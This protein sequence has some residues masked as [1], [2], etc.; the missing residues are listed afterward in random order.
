MASINYRP[1]GKSG[2]KVS[3][4]A[5]GGWTTF[6]ASVREEKKVDHILSKA[7]EAGINFFDMADVYAKGE[8]EKSMGKILKKFP[9]QH[10]VL[11]SKVFFPITQDPNDQGLSRKHIMESIHKSLKNIGS[12]YLDLYFCHRYD[13]QTPLEETVRAMDDLIHQGKILYWGTSEWSAQQLEAVQKLCAQKNYYTPIVEQAQYSLVC[14]KKFEEEILPVLED[15]QLGSVTWSPLGSGILTG[16]YDQGIPPDSR[17]GQITWLQE[18]FYQEK[19]LESVKQFKKIAEALGVSRS[20]LA[21]AW[22]KAQKGVT[23]VILGV[24]QLEQLEENLKALEISL[25]PKTDTDLRE[26][27]KAF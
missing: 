23:S 22:T 17:L 4:F 9:R 16:K 5:L 24:T 3:E 27:F 11:S 12:D 26:I 1:I 13:P 15:H 19:I 25:N 2:I 21:L 14:R 10:L 7:F 18:S 8:C 6:G 20:Q